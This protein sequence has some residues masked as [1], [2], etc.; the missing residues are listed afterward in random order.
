[1]RNLET[2]N[3]ISTGHVTNIANYR[4]SR[5]RTFYGNKPFDFVEICVP[6]CIL[7]VYVLSCDG[8]MFNLGAEGK[9]T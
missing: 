8:P 6:T 5:W 4:N 7:T 1:M 3:R 9:C 2:G